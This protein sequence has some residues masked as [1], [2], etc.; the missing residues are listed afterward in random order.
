MKVLLSRLLD[1]FSVC[2][3]CLVYSC[4]IYRCCAL[5]TLERLHRVAPH[6]TDKA[7]YQTP[8]I[9]YYGSLCTPVNLQWLTWHYTESVWRDIARVTGNGK[10]KIPPHRLQ[11]DIIIYTLRVHLCVKYIACNHGGHVTLL[12][13]SRSLANPR[14]LKGHEPKAALADLHSQDGAN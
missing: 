8:T 11:R 3:R 1:Y 4:F 12:R 6:G 2:V 13:E 14:P 5:G 7:W 10:H 9:F